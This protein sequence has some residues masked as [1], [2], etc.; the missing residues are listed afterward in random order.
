[1]RPFLAGLT[2]A[3]QRKIPRS[4]MSVNAKT[5]NLTGCSRK[6]DVIPLVLSFIPPFAFSLLRMHGYYVPLY[7]EPFFLSASYLASPSFIAVSAR[8][9]NHLFHLCYVSFHWREVAQ[10]RRQLSGGAVSQIPDFIG[11]KGLHS[12]S[13][14]FHVHGEILSRS[15]VNPIHIKRKFN[16]PLSTRYDA[17]RGMQF[18]RTVLDSRV[19]LDTTLHCII[20]V[21]RFTLFSYALGGQLAANSAAAN[22][23]GTK[24]K[25]LLFTFRN[26]YKNSARVNQW[27]ILQ[28]VPRD[29]EYCVPGRTVYN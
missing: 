21:Q 9:Y 8:R 28:K 15:R 29:D 19:K 18:L 22:E 1:M 12:T 4:V 5:L 2:R 13:R 27:L 25:S 10:R 24:R 26:M 3:T 14:R 23:K 20:H 7:C 16:L 6:S 17:I 11:V